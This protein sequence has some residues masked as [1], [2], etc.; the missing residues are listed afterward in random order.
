M[1]AL[2][3][4]LFAFGSSGKSALPC[5]YIHPKPTHVVQ[6]S[7]N[8]QVVQPVGQLA[9][10]CR[11]TTHGALQLRLVTSGPSQLPIDQFSVVLYAPLGTKV[12]SR[13]R[14]GSG[15]SGNLG[16]GTDSHVEAQ[17]QM[18]EDPVSS[19]SQ[20]LSWAMRV[21]SSHRRSPFGDCLEAF[22]MGPEFEKSAN[23][24]LGR[25]LVQPFEE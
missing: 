9:E 6:T 5:P 25:C 17:R 20:D 3:D 14:K 2:F 13:L 12:A 16:L 4:L 8:K 15:P 7:L 11:C 23:M 1:C 18:D 24:T 10:F 19:G 22:K 21:L